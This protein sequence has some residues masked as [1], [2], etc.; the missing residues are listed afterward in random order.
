MDF[1]ELKV[2]QRTP[3]TPDAVTLEL[4]VPEELQDVFQY[5]QGQYL[6]IRHEIN[7]QELRRSYSMSSSPNEGKLAITVKKVSG[8]KMSGF[9]HDQVQVGDRLEVARPDGRFFHPLNPDKRHTYYL[10]G[11]GSGITPLLSILKTILEAEPMSAVYLLYGSRDEENIIFRDELDALSEK[12]QGQLFVEYVLSQ[13]KK[14]KGGGL[15]GIFK[16]SSSNWQGRTGR[17]DARAAKTFLDN[18]LPHGPEELC[19]YFI[20]G[21][22][23]M[24]DAVKGALIAK[25]IEPKQIH[26]EHFVNAHHVPGDII[27]AGDS[28]DKK[29]IVHLKGERIELPVPGNATILDVLVKAKF[30]PPYSCTSGACS[31]CMAKL[32]NGKV[33][34]DACYALDDDEVQAGYILTCQSHPETN[35]VELSY[36]M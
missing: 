8:G 15:F 7:G 36:D 14:E 33:K 2:K 25:G 13:P 35:I 6:T 16:K 23:D 28:N 24:A 27:E 21:P 3:E 11:A 29:I 34:M 9:L 4:E 32:I 31:T 26:T 5:K 12:Y 30:D 18:N 10:F 19:I 1:F 20:C 17:V 22:G